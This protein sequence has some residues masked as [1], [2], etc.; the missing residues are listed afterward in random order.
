MSGLR[1]GVGYELFAQLF[2]GFGGGGAFVPLYFE[3]FAALHGGPG[4]VGDDG[5]AAVGGSAAAAGFELNDV[6]DSGNG[7][8]FGGVEGGDFAVED[9]A[10][11]YDSVE[12]TCGS[13]VD[14]VDSFAGG[15]GGGVDAGRGVADDGEVAGIF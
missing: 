8:G 13:R 12:K 11:G 5:D 6:A 14:A 2:A 10:A 15:F 3:S 7:F 9:G 4:I 1:G